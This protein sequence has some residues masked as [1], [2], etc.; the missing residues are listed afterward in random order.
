MDG[1]VPD[2]TWDNGTGELVVDPLQCVSADRVGA[3]A[4]SYDNQLVVFSSDDKIV[5]VY[6]KRVCKR[7]VQPLS[8]HN[9][10][11][12]SIALSHDC[13]YVTSSKMAGRLEC[14]T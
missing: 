10:P 3:I 2:L 4:F 5:P 11:D 9:H 1:Q 8:G 13:K 14:R 6:S 12:L 7:F